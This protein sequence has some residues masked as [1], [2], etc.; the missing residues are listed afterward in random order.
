MVE[1]KFEPTVAGEFDS[2]VQSGG[3]RLVVNCKLKLPAAVGQ[4]MAKLEP[5]NA[6]PSVVG[7]ARCMPVVFSVKS[8]E[9]AKDPP[10]TAKVVPNRV[11]TVKFAESA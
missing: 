6:K 11:L 9:S 2:V 5:F 7:V 10:P 8:A 1:T 3:F 4:L